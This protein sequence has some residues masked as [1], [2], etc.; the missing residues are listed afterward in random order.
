MRRIPWMCRRYLEFHGLLDP[1]KSQKDFHAGNKGHSAGKVRW[2]IRNWPSES[3]VQTFKVHMSSL[4]RSY[5]KLVSHH[6]CQEQ[7][8]IFTVCSTPK[9]PNLPVLQPSSFSAQH[10]TASSGT[11]SWSF[12]PRL[13][14]VQFC[15]SWNIGFSNTSRTSL[16]TFQ[17]FEFSKRAIL[18]VVQ[19]LERPPREAKAAGI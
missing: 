3:L 12:V 7:Q 11:A 9:L 5:P 15:G 8:T 4:T 13:I 17:D 18:K 2:C 14:M 10:S 6:V 19:R 16:N 1:S